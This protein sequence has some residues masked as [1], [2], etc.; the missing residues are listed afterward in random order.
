M[1]GSRGNRSQCNGAQGECGAV[2]AICYWYS[3]YT[4]GFRVLLGWT[5]LGY[6]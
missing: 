2:E 4:A 5:G 1:T 6:R 3:M